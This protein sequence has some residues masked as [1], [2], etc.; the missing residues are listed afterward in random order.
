MDMISLIQLIEGR[1]DRFGLCV[2]LLDIM[3]SNFTDLE[4][5]V[6]FFHQIQRLVRFEYF[7]LS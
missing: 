1:I 7:S 2:G 6:S 3:F 5:E 4:L